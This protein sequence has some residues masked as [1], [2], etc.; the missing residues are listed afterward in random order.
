M[1]LSIPR[2]SGSSQASPTIE[3]RQAVVIL[4]QRLHYLKRF[5]LAGCNL[6]EENTFDI[7]RFGMKLNSLHLHQC[8]VLATESLISTIVNER[9]S[10]R[11]QQEPF[12]LFI[13]RHKRNSNT[14]NDIETS[15]YLVVGW[16]CDHKY[17]IN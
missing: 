17:L 11:Q 3:Q 10:Y 4:V 14:I 13:D 8:E 9:K 15:R 6:T 2:G 5:D 12:K 7:I 1:H 16:K